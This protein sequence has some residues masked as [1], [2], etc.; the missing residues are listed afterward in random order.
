MARLAHSAS[1][2]S[3]RIADILAWLEVELEDVGL[4]SRVGGLGGACGRPLFIE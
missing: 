1:K 4:G 2:G 3:S